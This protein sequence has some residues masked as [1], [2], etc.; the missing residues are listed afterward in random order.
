MS[1]CRMRRIVTRR[2]YPIGGRARRGRWLIVRLSPPPPQ[3]GSRKR[4]ASSDYPLVASWP[5]PRMIS[6]GSET[7]QVLDQVVS[8]LV[9]Q[10]ELEEG[11]VVVDHVFEGGETAVVIEAGLLVRPQATEWCGAVGVRGRTFRLE[12]VDAHLRRRMEIVAGFRVER[13]HVATRALPLAGE[14]GFTAVGRLG[15]ERSGGRLRRRNRQLVVVQ[16]GEF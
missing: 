16:G 14:Q 5:S 6:W 12:R 2:I 13:G 7:Q 3:S 8:L 1:M 10:P 4:E 9:G 11:V 15:V